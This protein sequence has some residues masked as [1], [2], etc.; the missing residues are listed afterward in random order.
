MIAKAFGAGEKEKA[1]TYSSLC[2]WTAIVLAIVFII[3]VLIFADPLLVFLGA[4][5]DV[6]VYAKRYMVP[7]VL[8]SPFMMI[9]T[10]VAL[11]LRAEGSVMEGFVGNLVGTIVNLVLDPVFILGLHMGVQGA[12]IASVF[13]NVLAVFYYIYVIRKKS[14]TMSFSLVYA[15]K[16]VPAI[17]HILILGLPNAIAN[18]LSGFAS[19]FSNQILSTYGTDA[20]ASMAAA[21]KCTMITTTL[22]M[23]VGMGCQ[24]LISYNYGARNIPRLKEVVRK[25]SIV[26]FG[27]SM[28]TGTLCMIFRK[29]IMAQF[30]TTDVLGLG[31]HMVT[32]LLLTTP[33][34]GIVYVVSGYFQAI[35]RPMESLI[36]SILRQGLVLIPALYICN[37]FAGLDGVVWAYVI[38]DVVAA[39]V[40]AVVYIA[41]GKV[42]LEISPL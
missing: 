27:I 12:A 22:V 10:S 36:V 11:L 39:V 9:S 33:I 4:K 40:A 6:F 35:D 20:L 5:G 42:V 34:I 1:K 3:L 41:R 17:G 18:I 38:A 32:I 29:V 19:T 8:G 26:V 23:S 25:L 31:V 2:I 13:G 28:V 24:A 16:D 7:I 14:Q 21:G 15:S 30:L 37:H